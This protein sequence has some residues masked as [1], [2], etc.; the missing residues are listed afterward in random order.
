MTFKICSK[1]LGD[2][3]KTKGVVKIDYPDGTDAKSFKK[4]GH[5]L[6]VDKFQSMLV[7][8]TVTFAFDKDKIS[9]TYKG[10]TTIPAGSVLNAELMVVDD[11]KPVV[12]K[13]AAKKTAKK[14]ETKT[15][16]K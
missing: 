3:V 15:V 5:K 11:F 2:D 16:K 8:P 9:V 12:K 14:A 1:S 7:S 4:E 13:K 6:W 10:R